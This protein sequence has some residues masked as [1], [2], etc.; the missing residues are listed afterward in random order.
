LHFLSAK[1]LAASA[2]AGLDH[3]ENARVVVT[4]ALGSLETYIFE[5]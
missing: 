1:L 5:R 3:G 4:H 2:D